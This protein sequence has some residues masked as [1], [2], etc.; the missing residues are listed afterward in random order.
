MFGGAQLA[1]RASGYRLWILRL[2]VRIEG[3]FLVERVITVLETSPDTPYGRLTIVA[4]THRVD[5]SDLWELPGTIP[6]Q[7]AGTASRTADGSLT[8][9]R[10]YL[11]HLQGLIAEDIIRSEV[12]RGRRRGPLV[13]RV[14]PYAD[15]GGRALVPPIPVFIN[16]DGSLATRALRNHYFRPAYP[17]DGSDEGERYRTPPLAR[18][19]PGGELPRGHPGDREFSGGQSVL[20]QIGSSQGAPGSS[21][22][23]RQALDGTQFSGGQS[24]DTMSAQGSQGAAAMSGQPGPP[25]TRRGA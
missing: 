1:E 12:A 8:F 6:Y 14:N 9:G 10:T 20:R 4:R 3:V 17:P 25:D 22:V 2:V 13:N 5:W 11:I 16:D 21:G 19:W 7:F 18:G 15:L 23:P 24:R